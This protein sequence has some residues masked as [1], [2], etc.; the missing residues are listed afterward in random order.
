[1]EIIKTNCIRKWKW[2]AGNSLTLDRMSSCS[3]QLYK[4]NSEAVIVKQ[5]QQSN[6]Y[7]HSRI[8]N[9]KILPNHKKRF[10]NAARVTEPGLEC[11]P[12]QFFSISNENFVCAIFHISQTDNMPWPKNNFL[13]FEIGTHHKKWTKMVGRCGYEFQTTEC[14]Y[15]KVQPIFCFSCMA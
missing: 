3:C 5:T 8:E 4:L 14:I 1:M 9:F 6:L 10:G 2:K 13:S 11:V 15:T 7:L 12:T